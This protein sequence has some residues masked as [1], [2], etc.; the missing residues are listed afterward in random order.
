MFREVIGASETFTAHITVIRPFPRMDPQMPGQITLTPERPAAEQT[1]KR[2][3]PRMLPHMQLQILL[4]PYTFTTKRACESSF[5]LPFRRIRPQET[6]DGSLLGAA[7]GLATAS[8]CGQIEGHRV[9][10]VVLFGFCFVSVGGCCL[11]S[12]FVADVFFFDVDG[13]GGVVFFHCYGFIG[14]GHLIVA[15]F[16]GFIRFVG[17]GA[18]FGFALFGGVFGAFAMESFQGVVE[19]VLFERFQISG[20]N[21]S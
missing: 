6:D 3:L 20:K 11:A 9:D 21:Q 1:N 17:G 7:E 4:G 10:G 2:P 13:G 14:T 18:G 8:R 12:D 5:P 16:D 19:A 15:V